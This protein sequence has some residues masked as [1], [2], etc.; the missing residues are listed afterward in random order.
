MSSLIERLQTRFEDEFHQDQPLAKFTSA[1]VGG[2][3]SLFVIAR[4]RDELQLAAEL[5]YEYRIPYF[6]LGGGS[7]ILVSDEGVRGLV[8]QNRCKRVKYR[9]NGVNVVCT[10][11]SG[12]NLSSLA[13]QCINKGLSGLEW[14]VSVPGTVG[15]AVF[16]NAGAHGSDT[17]A[18]L[19]SATVWEPGKGM[20][21]MA[22]DEMQ[23]AYRE[24]AL[25]EEVRKGR[26]R[27]V[28][29]SAEFELV[30]EQ[31]SV[32]QARADG[33]VAHRKETQPSGATMG[34]MFKN[35]EHF[36][37]GYLIDTAGLKGTRMGGVHISKKHANFFLNDDNATAKDIVNLL[38][39][40]Y[41]QV[42]DDFN[43]EL[44]PEVELVG[45]WYFND[46]REENSE[47]R[48]ADSEE[49]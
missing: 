17:K 28:I 18:N 4:T 2:K 13:R 44:E 19:V 30:P 27:P 6:V 45:D 49:L 5:A 47:W 21:Y 42:R 35:P 37:A 16:G 23:Y 9:S 7:N 24:S 14:A 15:G 36:Y 8:I 10:A 29:L 32:L 26:P 48:L 39:F 11:D 31:V 20:R 41:Q 38:D 12:T 22:N 33:F 46:K 3:A 34:S 1:R 43:V 25:K 40:V